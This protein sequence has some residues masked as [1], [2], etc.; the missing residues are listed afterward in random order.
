MDK[1]AWPSALLN[2]G[3]MPFPPQGLPFP[4]SLLS[5]PPSVIITCRLRS[6]VP[7][8]RLCPSACARGK[9]FG[10]YPLPSSAA[11]LLP[12]AN[13]GPTDLDPDAYS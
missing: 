9:S 6:N 10:P 2:R 3:P 1:S 7:R 13:P 8:C 11:P 5:H 12:P 4:S